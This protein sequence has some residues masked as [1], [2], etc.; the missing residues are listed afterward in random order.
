MEQKEDI[1]HA[2]KGSK[3]SMFPIAKNVARAIRYRMAYNAQED[4]VQGT[5]KGILLENRPAS[6]D[7]IFMRK[8]KV[9]PS[10]LNILSPVEMKSLVDAVE[11]K[12]NSTHFTSI[13]T[14]DIIP[15]MKYV[16][17]GEGPISEAG[18]LDLLTKTLE[19][20]SISE[21]YRRCISVL[22]KV[23]NMN[24][25]K[26]F[27][28]DID[29]ENFA[30]Y[31][32]SMRQPISFFTVSI[33]LL[34][35]VYDSDGSVGA[36]FY[37]DLRQ[38]LL[39]CISVNTEATGLVAQ[40]QKL[41]PVIHRHVDRWVLS[42]DR[43]SL[44]RC[45]E[46][47]CVM[48]GEA[49]E[50]I[51]NIITS[52]KC[53]R[54]CGVFSIKFL[55]SNKATMTG[56]Y[57]MSTEL[58]TSPHEA[59][60]CPL[61]L[62][63]RSCDESFSRS[64]YIDEWGPSAQIPWILNSNHC[65]RIDQISD[66]VIVN[67]MDAIKLLACDDST[68]LKSENPKLKRWTMSERATVL[69]ALVDLTLASS[70]T[71][72][73]TLSN[74]DTCQK[75]SKIANSEPFRTGDF[76]N[77]VCSVAGEQ[78]AYLTR[79]ILMQDSASKHD[80][81]NDYQF[82]SYT[83]IMDGR[84]IICRRFTDPQEGDVD[85]Q[86]VVVICDGCSS[87]V[88]LACLKLEKVPTDEW[89][90]EACRQMGHGKVD[91]NRY[92]SAFYTLIDNARRGDIED[93]LLK[94]YAQF[95]YGSGPKR[96][97][98]KDTCDYCYKTELELC[99]PLVVGQSLPEFFEF[100]SKFT[101]PSISTQP[102]IPFFPLASDQTKTK[103]LSN[104]ELVK[105]P[106]THEMCALNMHRNRI[107]MKK[108]E[109]RKLRKTISKKATQALG[110]YLE[111]LG[112]DDEA[113]VYWK[114][115]TSPDLFVH[116]SYLVDDEYKVALKDGLQDISVTNSLGKDE[117]WYRVCGTENIN[118][119]IGLLGLSKHESSLRS[120]LLSTFTFLPMLSDPAELSKKP[121]IYS[122]Q[123]VKSREELTGIED[124]STEPFDIVSNVFSSENVDGSSSMIQKG[125]EAFDENAIVEMTFV[126]EKGL[127]IPPY[128]LIREEDVYEPLDKDFDDDMYLNFFTYTK[129]FYAVA[130]VNSRGRK[131][132][133]KK[134]AATVTY[135]VEYRYFIEK[136]NFSF[137]RI[138]N[139]LINRFLERVI[140][141][142]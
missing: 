9:E 69:T 62:Q 27:F 141:N 103:F 11:D 142:P 140:P 139:Y 89:Y 124:K 65:T 132:K 80:E 104:S 117:Y 7:L 54:C 21:D 118:T 64:F 76:L 63:D 46:K 95:N 122:H 73:W 86:K 91:T 2:I 18:I 28:W 24:A 135:Q 30:D 79:K 115:P 41:L 96:E 97:F 57:D 116:V 92:H 82:N 131:V 133:L 23:M 119:L 107:D 59:W 68:S 31:C 125:E 37:I 4:T 81:N 128:I 112:R 121:E 109:F 126:K 88:H 12:G 48:S 29:D 5:T 55:E 36:Q 56:I 61:C 17:I 25:A 19:D 75:L 42:S 123:R 114:F 71:Q 22:L 98:G 106:V 93:K 99:S 35:S 26:N 138:F 47:F 137:L 85:D 136:G 10:R 72:N 100:Q 101:K 39:N 78:A 87:E 120:A 50:N 20:E 134:N 60:L 113:R 58:I 102:R 111:P 105:S 3:A 38:V 6:E 66:S 74:F 70:K 1:L 45:N 52:V 53:G 14:S 8:F 51:P 15:S 127:S 16:D 90:C 108:A 94:H 49:I 40:A 84:C 43:Q 33:K 13:I 129:K 67:M 130:L 110:L 34:Q 44:N 83:R 77:A 32:N